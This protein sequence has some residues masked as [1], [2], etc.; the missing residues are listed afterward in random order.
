[1][2]RSY[3]LTKSSWCIYIASVDTNHLGYA[4]PIIEVILGR[5]QNPLGRSSA[6]AIYQD[7]L[8]CAGESINKTER[9]S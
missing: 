5:R 4:A 6:G 8:K 7:D 3:P 9:L 1:M 2:G